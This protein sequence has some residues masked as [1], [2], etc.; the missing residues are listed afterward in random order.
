MSEIDFEKL[1]NI[2]RSLNIEVIENPENSGL[3]Y[4]D[5]KG[6]LVKFDIR[7]VLDI[8]YYYDKEKDNNGEE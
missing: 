8:F 1:N 4:K 5:K 6:N 3:F 2:A 7:E